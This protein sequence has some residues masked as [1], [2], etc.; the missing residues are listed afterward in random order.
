MTRRRTTI[1]G[2]F[3]RRRSGGTTRSPNTQPA[4]R[5]DPTLPQA[6]YGMGRVFEHQGRPEDAI[7]AYQSA[8]QHNPQHVDAHVALAGL[9]LTRGDKTAAINTFEAAL[10]LAPDVPEGHYQVARLLDDVGRRGEAL[11][12][13]RRFVELATPA[14]RTPAPG[15]KRAS[16]RSRPPSRVS[17]NETGRATP[18]WVARPAAGPW[19]W[20]DT[21][22][23]VRGNGYVFRRFEIRFS[24]SMPE[25]PWPRT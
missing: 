13:Y 1:S 4:A 2:R 11:S 18:P 23:V 20:A 14:R 3:T 12:H 10:R 21:A 15:C 9:Y 6:H 24:A 22:S 8:V 25:R 17:E 7:R 5:I 19:G 16:A